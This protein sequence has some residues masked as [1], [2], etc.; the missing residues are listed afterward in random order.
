[1]A[2]KKDI[3]D[4]AVESMGGLE[5]MHKDSLHFS[6]RSDIMWDNLERWAMEHPNKWAALTDDDQLLLAD[7]FDDLLRR[8]DESGTRRETLVFRYLDPSPAGTGSSSMLRGEFRRAT[9]ELTLRG[10]VWAPASRR[11]LEVDFVVDTGRKHHVA[12][13]LRHGRALEW[14]SRCCRQPRFL[15]AASGGPLRS[16]DASCL[17]SFEDGRSIHFY[18]V[19]ASVPDPRR[20]RPFALHPRTRCAAAMADGVRRT[21]LRA[22]LH[23]A[24]RRPHLH[25][26]GDFSASSLA[27]AAWHRPSRT[28]AILVAPMPL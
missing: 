15:S 8:V 4:E 22:L 24:L 5:Q 17:L 9:G 25:T 28:A 23:G 13:P 16:Y 6:R 7:D 26:P 2:R 11:N 3:F 10:K 18:R 20:S 27:R 19:T 14:T 1:M 12:A 21:A